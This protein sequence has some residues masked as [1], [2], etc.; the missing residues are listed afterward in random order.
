M[1]DKIYIRF[2]KLP[3]IWDSPMNVNCGAWPL[4]GTWGELI[5]SPSNRRGVNNVGVHGT[6]PSSPLQSSRVVFV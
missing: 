6:I 3:D 2:S 1:Y 5:V 4:E